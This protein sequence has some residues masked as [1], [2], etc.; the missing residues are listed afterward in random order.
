M[1]ARLCLASTARLTTGLLYEERASACAGALD[2]TC[3]ILLLRSC[4]VAYN[5]IHK[6]ANDYSS[7]IGSGLV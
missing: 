6:L 7:G 5:I 2:N 1:L 4:L 3:A